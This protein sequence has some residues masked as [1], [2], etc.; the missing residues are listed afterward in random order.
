V[1]RTSDSGFTALTAICTHQACTITG[2]A[3][4]EYVCP[5]HGS[6]FGLN[7]GVLSG[8]APRAL[9]SFATRFANGVLTISI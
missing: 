7:G 2:F 1:A 5:C 9:R 6:R 8:P 3:S 4:Q